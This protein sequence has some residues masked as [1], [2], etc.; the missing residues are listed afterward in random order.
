MKR[1]FSIDCEFS[2]LDHRK[3]CLLSI[4]IIEIKKENKLWK[5]DHMRQFYI[6][7]KP[8][9]KIDQE[10]MKI[11]GLNEEYLESFGSN[12]QEV[13]RQLNKYLD[14]NKNDIAIFIAYCGVLDKIFIDQIYQDLG[15]DSSP[16]HYEIIE[17]SSLALGKLN[18]EW[19]FS[20][21][22]LLKKLKIDDLKSK[23]KHNALSDAILQAKQYCKII[24]YF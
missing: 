13:I 5:P 14:L 4:G 17:L 2:G 22:E 3:N 7:L 21:V 1:Y 15:Y 11:N 10:A 18:F 19:G 9:G 23:E 24:N 6:E 12:K 20:E 8:S 16:F